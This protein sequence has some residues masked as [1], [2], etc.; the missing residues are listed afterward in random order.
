MGRKGEEKA[1]NIFSTHSLRYNS[2]EGW[3]A[4]KALTSEI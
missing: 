2:T 3:L 1:M 4:H